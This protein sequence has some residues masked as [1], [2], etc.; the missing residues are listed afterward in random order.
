M[1]RMLTILVLSVWC[2]GANAQISSTVEVQ[3]DFEAG[4]GNILK[5]PLDPEIPDTLH[6]FELNFD[7]SIFDRKYTD[8]Y[9]FTPMAAADLN[10]NRDI[11]YP[12]LYVDLNYGSLV[13]PQASLYIQ[14]RLGEKHSLVFRGSHSSLWEG[15]M[16]ED[17][18][19]RSDTD[20][21]AHYRYHFRRG[22]IRAGMSF[23]NS[24]R[25]LHT[26]YDWTEPGEEEESG[27]IKSNIMGAYLSSHSPDD[28]T[29]VFCYNVDLKYHRTMELSENFLDGTIDVGVSL[30]NTHRFLLGAHIQNAGNRSVMEA[31]PR[32]RFTS[33][34][35][36]IDAAAI[37]TFATEQIDRT[38]A[39]MP[40]AHVSFQA[41]RNSLRLFVSA[42]GSNSL[43]SAYRLRMLNPWAAIPADLK[44]ECIP[45][46]AEAGVRGCISDIFTYELSGGWT[47]A[48]NR[49]SFEWDQ[50]ARYDECDWFHA[51]AAM[52]LATEKVT[53]KLGARYNIL[54]QG[55]KVYMK[56]ELEADA[57]VTANIRQR[58][59]ITI[60]C[61][62]CTESTAA[63]TIPSVSGIPDDIES[64]VLRTLPG[65]VNPGAEVAYHIT[66]FLSARIFGRNLLNQDIYHVS[67]YREKGI[68]VGAGVTLKL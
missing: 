1:K 53:A 60:N 7:Y 37:F 56:P 34:R 51:G 67:E 49:L 13:A 62:L 5:S 27:E 8:L 46:E 33:G 57:S 45:L 23:T 4:M 6:R 3:K 58:W 35:W 10:R 42:V 16:D 64:P 26:R 47:Y 2:M 24:F 29:S 52:Y 15:K 14:P 21:G 59:F 61:D 55:G 11:R 22:E 20:A 54:P 66:P 63:T 38:T 44:N 30:R 43:G 65:Y 17:L 12:W 39:I 41:V 18:G 36:D 48:L 25:Q 19:N 9:D 50:T 32:Y 40:R 31:I 68:T 28:G